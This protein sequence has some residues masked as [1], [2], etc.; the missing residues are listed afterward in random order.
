MSSNHAY[1]DGL[2]N[3]HGDCSTVEG[4]GTPLPASHYSFVPPGDID[5]RSVAQDHWYSIYQ[6]VSPFDNPIAFQQTSLPTDNGSPL[7]LP[8]TH[9][10]TDG[11]VIDPRCLDTRYFEPECLPSTL[12]P[13]EFLYEQHSQH[14]LRDFEHP[15]QACHNDTSTNTTTTPT[16]PNSLYG[17]LDMAPLLP[18]ESFQGPAFPNQRQTLHLLPVQPAKVQTHDSYE[19]P[20]LPPIGETDKA[21][22]PFRQRPSRLMSEICEEPKCRRRFRPTART[23]RFCTRHQKKYERNHAN[24]PIFE[25]LPRINI[26]IA[27]NVVYPIIP[28]LGLEHDDVESRCEADWVSDFIDAVNKPYTG[29]SQYDEFHTRQQK[30]YNGK[31][32]DEETVN[33]RLRVLY[34]AALIFHEGGMA[35]YPV[36]GDNDGYGAPDKTMTFSE[37]LRAIISILEIDKRVCMDAI[38]GRGVLALVAN[39]QKYAKRKVQNKDSNE[40]KQRLQKLGDKIWE[41]RK[42]KGKRVECSDVDTDD[43][44]EDVMQGLKSH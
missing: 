42:A 10:Y 15:L 43:D 14:Y 19:K 17:Q 26:Q 11:R 34:E 30:V 44:G 27:F 6:S 31:G 8:T 38:E 41:K 4:V 3:D 21:T 37:R 20:Q 2:W 36:G 22:A 33:V 25:M 1:S 24:P 5:S 9:P 13:Q 18:R 32:Y 35:V 16:L 39:P 7:L 23:M 29:G 40:R 28:A 12:L